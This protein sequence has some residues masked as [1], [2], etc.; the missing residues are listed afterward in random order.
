MFGG[1]KGDLGSWSIQVFDEDE[2]RLG[3][4]RVCLGGR[5]RDRR[6]GSDFESHAW[7]NENNATQLLAIT[8]RRT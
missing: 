1:R 3:Q 4:V 8:S 5:G 7:L 6:I 2:V